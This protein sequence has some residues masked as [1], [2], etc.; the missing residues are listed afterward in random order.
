MAVVSAR[1]SARFLASGWRQSPVILVHG[2][3]EGGVRDTVAQLLAAAMG[4]DFDPM[5]MVVLDGDTLAAD[6]PRLADEL[7]TFGLFGGLRIVHVRG[8]GKAP[9]AAVEMAADE[10]AAETLLILEA[11]DLNKANPLRAL[12]ERHRTIAALPCYADTARALHGLIDQILGAGNL[13]ITRDAREALTADL[14]ADRGLSRSEIEKLALYAR[15]EQEV[16][17]AM[18]QAIVAD[19]GRHDS[20]TLID[21]ALSGALATIEP[22]ANRMFAAG[23]NPAAILAQLSGHLF[24]LRRALRNGQTPDEFIRQRRIHF[25]RSAAITR[26]LALWSEERINRAL[27]QVSD[28][29]LQTRTTPR[30]AEALTIRTLWALGRMA[31]ARR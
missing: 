28:A 21:N 23:T 6:P 24:L 20:T 12:C 27:A 14:G 9:A 30:L 17:L 10:P 1:D 15:G 31:G 11:G 4:R 13:T 3:D 19:A 22:E 2:S 26:T 5:N 29:T 7:R 25:S 16:T 18:V 8:A